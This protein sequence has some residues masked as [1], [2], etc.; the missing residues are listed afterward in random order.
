MDDFSSAPVQPRGSAVELQ[1]D[2]HGRVQVFRNDTFKEQEL[3]EPHD[4]RHAHELSTV[5]ETDAAADEHTTST[6]QL[7]DDHEHDP[8]HDDDHDHDCD[9]EQ[10]QAYTTRLELSRKKSLESYV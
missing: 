1:I 4:S 7:V 6:Y 8:D 5:E 10:A 9:G 2:M 3:Q